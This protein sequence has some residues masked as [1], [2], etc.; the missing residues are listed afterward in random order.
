MTGRVDAATLKAWLSDGGEIGLLDVREHG[1]HGEGHPF[2]AVSL[3][4][5]RFELGLI[6]LVPNPAVRLVLC[7]GADGVAERAARRA[8]AMG[9]G[10]ASLLAGGVQGWREAGYTLYAGV[11]V[12]S[13][14]LKWARRAVEEAPDRYYAW[15]VQ[16]RC[17]QLLGLD[18]H[19][20]KSYQR[21]LELSPR[22]AEAGERLREM[23]QD[24]WSLKGI[25]RKLRFRS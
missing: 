2:F 25:L 22:H 3:P 7:D 5:S 10:N 15:Y 4:Y 17:Q 16:G 23:E 11:N 14:A 9:Y 18:A 13:K 21:C 24:R 20:R 12:P 19:A 6:S 1:Q 8:E